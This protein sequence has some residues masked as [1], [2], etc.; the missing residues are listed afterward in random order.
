M[1][2]INHLKIMLFKYVYILLT[3]NICTNNGINASQSVKDSE[4]KHNNIYLRGS[5]FE[6]QYI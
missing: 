4:I 5:I 6:A 2:V 1:H 3:S